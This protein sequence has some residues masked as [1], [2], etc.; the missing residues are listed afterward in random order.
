MEEVSE[1]QSYSK[2]EWI[3]YIIV[4]PL[5][6]TLVLSGIIAQMFGYNVV[7]VLAKWLHQVPVVQKVLPAD[8]SSSSPATS[9]N[10]TD[11][12]TKEIDSLKKQL[13]T[14]DKQISD[15]TKQ[16]QSDKQTMLQT[17]TQAQDAKR[18]ADANK[19][20]LDQD[21]QKQL[22]TLA[23]IYT[24]MSPSKAAPIMER[25]TL[26]EASLILKTMQ[27]ADSSAIL[28]KMDPQKAADVSAILKDTT[29]TKD[30]DLAAMQKRIQ[31]LTDSLSRAQK[32]AATLPEM[33]NSFGSMDPDSAAKILLK[34]DQA[35]ERQVMA[36]LAQMNAQQRA[37]ILTS[38]SKDPKN[39]ETAARISQK[40]LVY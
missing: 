29:L 7:G 10:N 20:A 39:V 36:V 32:N 6:F 1:E 4:I 15:L 22:A 26:Q 2:L 35:N 23:N 13:Q 5:L 19:Q 11:A 30:T 25:L 18:T 9:A 40:L 33:V 24:S 21:R 3:F 12:K 17:Q 37:Q 8:S 38:M 31:N 14:K 28:S 16:A 34:M 27:P